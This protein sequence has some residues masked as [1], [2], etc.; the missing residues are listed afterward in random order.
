MDATT[1]EKRRSTVVLRVLLGTVGVALLLSIAA[2]AVDWQWRSARQVQRLIP[3]YGGR[4]LLGWG[5]VDL[6]E[7]EILGPFV[8]W[9]PDTGRVAAA[10]WGKGQEVVATMWDPAGRVIGKQHSGRGI[11]WGAC[12]EFLDVKTHRLVSEQEMATVGMSAC[13]EWIAPWE[14]D[15]AS[16]D[17]WEIPS[18]DWRHVR[19]CFG[20][21]PWLN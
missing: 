20:V 19:R 2:F 12:E 7:E 8:L 3:D 5:V 9:Y 18:D 13:P 14:F 17:D 11:Y 16:V 10:G 4:W 1:H 21:L 15:G 6:A